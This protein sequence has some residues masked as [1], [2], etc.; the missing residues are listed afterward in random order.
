MDGMA[1]KCAH[2]TEKLTR[3][4][5]DRGLSNADLASA[6]GIPP[7][8][9]ARYFDGSAPRGHIALMIAKALDVDP[10]YMLDE[11]EPLRDSPPPF[12]S[13]T[14]EDAPDVTLAAALRQR[15]RERAG[16][17][18]EFIAKAE[19]IHWADIRKAVDELHSAGDAPPLVIAS[20]RILAA[21]HIGWQARLYMFWGVLHDGPEFEVQ[22]VAREDIN[23]ESLELPHLLARL[24]RLTEDVGDS[25]IANAIFRNQMLRSYGVD[26]DHQISSRKFLPE[27]EIAEAFK[28]YES[29]GGVNI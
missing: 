6:C 5:K 17:F 16:T 25:K 24:E 15:Y 29:S 11:N 28:A 22:T 12:K 13:Q 21:L 20:F 2:F 9:M 26:D 1:E 8:T 14:I 19:R 10:I 4:A 3:H 23:E 7:Q 18:A 27:S